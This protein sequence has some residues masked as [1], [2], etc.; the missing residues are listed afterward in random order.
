ML[1]KGTEIVLTLAKARPFQ[2][3]ILSQSE[4]VPAYEL[5]M[6][7]LFVKPLLFT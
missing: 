5:G 4:P 3:Q 2:S 6:K 1:A 7:V